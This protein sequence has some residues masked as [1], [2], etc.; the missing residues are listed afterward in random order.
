MK[1]SPNSKILKKNLKVLLVLLCTICGFMNGS[2]LVFFKVA[3]EVLNSPER[4]MNVFFSILMGLCGTFCAGLQIYCLNLSMKYYNNL[5]VMPIY[6]SMIL[7]LVMASGLIVLDESSK[8]SWGEL[9]VLFASATL[10]V[11]GIY[12]LTKKQ[13]LIVINGDQ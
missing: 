3:G 2:S 9:F 6:Q 8:Y 7:M 10:V 5:D 13:N 4:D 1:I 12:V 11:L